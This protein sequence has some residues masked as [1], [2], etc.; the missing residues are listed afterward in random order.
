MTIWLVRFL[1]YDG[2]G[3][4]QL[5]FRSEDAAQAALEAAITNAEEPGVDGYEDDFGVEIFVR[6]SKCA[7]VLT[8]TEM[9]AAS[10]AALEAAGQEGLRTYGLA[11]AFDPGS[12][13]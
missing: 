1:P 9:A 3:V 6:T 2:P 11:G 8:S 12:T 5:T 10:Q 4:H 7:I 13:H